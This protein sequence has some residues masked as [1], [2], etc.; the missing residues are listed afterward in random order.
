MAGDSQS[1][2]GRRTCVTGEA[3]SPLRRGGRLKRH[4]SPVREARRG[5]LDEA[6]RVDRANL[7]VGKTRAARSR[8]VAPVVICVRSA[9]AIDADDGAVSG[10]FMQTGPV[11]RAD[12]ATTGIGPSPLARGRS[13]TRCP[14]MGVL[15][16][17]EQ[18]AG[19][20]AWPG[21]P[22]AHQICA[23]DLGPPGLPA[24]NLDSA[25]GGF[26]STSPRR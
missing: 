6:P 13:R 21:C 10:R 1:W 8:D 23:G 17:L 14:D 16:N 25:G 15:S 12:S 3:L 19:G 5:T 9:H 11:R 4:Q 2:R 20:C 24:M 7:N 22:R 18:V 26:C